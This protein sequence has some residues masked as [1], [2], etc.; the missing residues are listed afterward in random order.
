MS[1]IVAPSN[2]GRWVEAVVAG[3]SAGFVTAEEFT[4][5]A[6]CGVTSGSVVSAGQGPVVVGLSRSVSSSSATFPLSSGPGGW[7][8][9][10]FVCG[11]KS[12][13]VA[14]EMFESA[15]PERMGR[16]PVGS[17]RVFGK[18]SGVR[19]AG[20]AAVDGDAL[21][22]DSAKTVSLVILLKYVAGCFVS[23]Q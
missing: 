10:A 7:P 4:T 5:V 2:V 1:I 22:V 18:E 23:V 12:S 3:T 11:I 19:V 6:G 16:A 21:V 17:T 15:G 9:C 8:G 14:A 13:W 20:S